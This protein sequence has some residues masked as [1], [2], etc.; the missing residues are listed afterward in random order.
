MA[1]IWHQP[2]KRSYSSD[3]RIVIGK[4]L[5]SLNPA[6]V[7]EYFKDKEHVKIGYDI[8][9]KKLYLVPVAKDDG[10]GMKIIANKK[11]NQRYINAKNIIPQIALKNDGRNEFKCSWD[12]VNKGVLVDIE[13]DII[14]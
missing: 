3:P 12:D 14:K 5:I 11:W 2:R 4:K 8:K 6:C 9:N 1:I 13:K 10:Y 7:E